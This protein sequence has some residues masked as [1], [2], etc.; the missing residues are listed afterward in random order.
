MLLTMFNKVFLTAFWLAVFIWA[1][2]VLSWCSSTTVSDEIVQQLPIATAYADYSAA[3]VKEAEA[4]G[5][6]VAVFFHSASCGSCGKLD[7]SISWNEG[8]LPSDVAIFK[9]DWASPE[10]QALAKEY[11]VDKYHT[12]SYKM[13]DGVK[14]VKGL[15]E[16]SDVVAEF[17]KPLEAK[18]DGG[19]QAYSAAAVK[20]AEAEGKKVAIFF[21][22]KTCGSCG[23]LDANINWNAVSIPNDVVIF[24]A[25]WDSSE[26]QAL[27]KEYGVDKYHTVTVKTE[28]WMKNVKGLFELSDLVAEFDTTVEANTAW[29]YLA[30]SSAAVKKAE[31]EG[32]KVAV[33]FH[34]KMCG[35]CGKL[36]SNI[37]WNSGTIPSD[38]AIFKADW[39]SSEAQALAKEYGVDKYHTVSVVKGDQVVNVKWLFELSKLLEQVS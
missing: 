18:V 12:V 30:Y 4:E 24:K 23:K 29:E 11:W 34:S 25:D 19:Y 17:D 37:S 35:S 10:G 39:D 2:G 1:W 6:K 38:V 15:F 21:H 31:A 7:A 14:N 9:A 16:A 33:F 26:A 3:A 22:S 32:K 8:K 28:E 13:K 27:A 36:D 5:K 20:K